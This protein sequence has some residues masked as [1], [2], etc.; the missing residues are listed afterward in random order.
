MERSTHSPAFAR[1][2]GQ[3]GEMST[4][5]QSR[6]RWVA[7]LVALALVVVAEP[8]PLQTNAGQVPKTIETK[9]IQALMLTGRNPINL[10]LLKP[11]VRGGAGGSLNSFHPDSLSDGGFIINGSRTDE[12]LVTIDGAIA[13]RTR[14]AGAIIGAVNVDTVQE[15]Q[16]LTANYIPQNGRSPGGQ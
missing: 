8:T 10:A 11:G 7:C 14:A 6:M 5:V 4:S 3:G 13:T 9:Q 2:H 12:N 1:P 16:V 15:I